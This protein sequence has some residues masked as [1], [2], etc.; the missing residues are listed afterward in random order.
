MIEEFTKQYFA[1][2]P[3]LRIKFTEDHPTDYLEVVRAVVEIMGEDRNGDQMDADR[4]HQIDDG[5]YQGTLVYVIGATGY[6]PTA[7]WYV[8]V[9]YGSCSGCDT[10]EAIRNYQD[11][12]PSD[13]QILTGGDASE[14]D[15][16]HT[17]GGDTYLVAAMRARVTAKF[18]PEVEDILAPK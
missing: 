4:I 5:D 3:G 13:D 14:L 7:Y 15:T 18:G 6:Q 8:K 17:A 12:K 9:G 16:E 11:E 10:L 1:K 2:L